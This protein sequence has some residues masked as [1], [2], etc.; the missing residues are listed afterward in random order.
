MKLNLKMKLKSR[1]NQLTFAITC[2]AAL[3]TF[4]MSS[5]ADE[6]LFANGNSINRYSSESHKYQGQFNQDR[7][8]A[9]DFDVEGEISR[10]VISGRGS[11][12]GGPSEVLGVFVRFYEWTST[13][14]GPLQQEY[15]LEGDDPDLE[16][17]RDGQP[18]LLNITLPESFAA[19]GTHFL[20]VQIEFS[21][22]TYGYW[23]IRRANYNNPTMQPAYRRDLL[24]G[25]TW[26]P[27]TDTQGRDSDIAFEL[28]GGPP[29]VSPWKFVESP[30]EDRAVLWGVQSIQDQPDDVWAVGHEKIFFGQ[31]SFDLHSL[32]IHWDGSTWTQVPTPSPGAYP[33]GGT[34]VSLNDV[35]G[36]ATDDVWAVGNYK[37]QHP[38]GF[39]GFQTFAIHWNGSDWSQVE[40]PITV[41]GTSGA[42]LDAVAVVSEN[43]VYAVGQM[44]DPVPGD[45]I[46]TNGHAIEWDGSEW[47][48]LPIPPIKGFYNEFRDLDIIG[49]GHFI[50]VGGHSGNTYGASDQPYVFEWEDGQWNE[51]TVPVPPGQNFLESVTVI[52]ADDIWI[53]GTNDQ[54]NEGFQ[55]LFIHF[56][57]Q[58]WSVFDDVTFDHYGGTIRS[59]DARSPT[60][61]WASGA[62]AI[63][64]GSFNRPLLMHYNGKDW[65][66]IAADP[67]GPD[68]G[69]FFDVDVF[70]QDVAW[71]V[72]TFTDRTHTQ[73][74][75]KTGSEVAATFDS[76]NIA[77]GT[78]IAG[79]LQ[80]IKESDDIDLRARSQFG[81]LSSE[82]NLVDIHFSGFLAGDSVDQLSV[83]VEARLNNPGG[84]V[85]LRLRDWD[86]NALDEIHAYTLGTSEMRETTSVA[87]AAQYIR[88]SDGRIE[89]SLKSVVVATFSL[90]GFQAEI[91]QVEVTT[92]D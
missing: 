69:F 13:G 72:G 45:Q 31:F 53:A 61:I 67:D 56:D 79:D 74:L 10:I 83:A 17:N 57:G 36:A 58:S 27:D 38:D 18:G 75:T 4:T 40:T 19:N 73:R 2:F 32:A 89:L 35:S 76:M 63:N 68:S 44:V 22:S 42:D 91:D 16:Y 49:P 15:Y 29:T 34:D 90:S 28:W 82:P 21:S 3:S 30:P 7:E 9:D 20:S 70:S 80:S 71:A 87:N 78:L 11:G 62:F 86:S 52:A 92:T 60:D 55:P 77:F 12:T 41:N 5:S 54:V 51:I 24:Q 65:Q 39:I 64:Q 26:E 25:G 6:L 84:S 48:M 66:Q 59:I 14:P 50:A 23:T 8:V 88:A 43:E 85:R 37:T 1:F 46:D 47:S 81:F 33:D